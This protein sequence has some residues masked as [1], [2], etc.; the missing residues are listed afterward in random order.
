[1]AD[2]IDRAQQEEEFFLTRAMAATKRPGLVACGRCHYCNENVEP[3][4]LFCGPECRD[5]FDHEQACRKRS[6]F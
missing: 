6:G 5:D 3:G 1:V 4:A 2:D